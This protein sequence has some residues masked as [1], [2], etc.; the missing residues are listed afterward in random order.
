M[1]YLIWSN[2]H[3]AWWNPNSAGYTNSSSAAGRYTRE[4]ALAIC[5]QA[6]DGWDSQGVPPEIP[7]LASDVAE[8]DA[9]QAARKASLEAQRKQ[10]AQKSNDGS[11]FGNAKFA[12]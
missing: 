3:N 10:H 1:D 12:S 4:K 6:R 9:M 7:V 11:K 5:R 2:E 8:L